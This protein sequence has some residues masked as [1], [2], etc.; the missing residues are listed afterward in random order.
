MHVY[1]LHD[2][3]PQPRKCTAC[4]ATCG[5]VQQVLPEE[6]STWSDPIHGTARRVHKCWYTTV[7]EVLVPH[8]RYALVGIAK[9]APLTVVSSPLTT[10]RAYGFIRSADSKQ[11]VGRTK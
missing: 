5:R 1:S 9:I 7:N 8:A 11:A 4:S 10:K 3:P 2:A 6:S